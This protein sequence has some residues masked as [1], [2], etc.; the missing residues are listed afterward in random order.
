MKTRLNEDCRMLL[1][2]HSQA[3]SHWFKHWDL[4]AQVCAFNGKE[5]F[6]I[7]DQRINDNPVDVK[8]WASII[9]YWARINDF[10]CE[11]KSINNKGDYGH[12]ITMTVDYYG[13]NHE[14]N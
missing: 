12:L 11:W 7:Y 5:S 10:F 3:R 6:W 13:R 1:R 9:C 8:A 4:K 14:Y 2:L